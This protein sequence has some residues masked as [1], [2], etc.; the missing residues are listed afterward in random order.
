M[1]S[2]S[3]RISHL[4]LSPS[5]PLFSVS[6]SSSLF[7]WAAVSPVL[8][9][10]VACQEILTEFFITRTLTLFQNLSEFVSSLVKTIVTFCVIKK[11][12]HYIYYCHKTYSKSAD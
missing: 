11:R 5:P 3:T 1:C 12:N 7:L 10:N 9:A 6:I 8:N 4:E 2:G